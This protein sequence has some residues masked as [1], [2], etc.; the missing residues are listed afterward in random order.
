MLNRKFFKEQ[1]NGYEKKQVDRYIDKLLKAYETVYRKYLEETEKN[2]I[3][4]KE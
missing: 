1:E 4:G 2:S 3:E